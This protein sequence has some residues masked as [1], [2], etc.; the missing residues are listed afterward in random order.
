MADVLFDIE[1]TGI[2]D[3]RDAAAN[4]QR[5]GKVS[6][7][8]ASQY[9]PL[10]SQTTRLVKEQ[11]RLE[12]SYKALAKAEKQNLI[13][14][15]E[16][17]RAMEEEI[18]VSKERILTDS[19]LIAQQRKKAKSEERSK[20]ETE[21]LTKAYAPARMAADLFQKKLKEIDR[22]AKGGIISLKEAAIATARTKTEFAQ[23]SAGLATGANQ[24][25]RFNTAAYNA[26]QKSKRFASV[27][28]QQV[29]YQV[30]DFIV[31]MQSGTD[32]LVAFGQQGSQL[33][34]IFGAKGAIFGAVIA[35]ATAIGMVYK[36]IVE[37]SKTSAEDIKTAF[38]TVPDYFDDLGLSIFNS[39]DKSFSK[40][41]DRYG[42][43]IGNLARTQLTSLQDAAKS[44]EGPTVKSAQPSIYERIGSALAPGLVSG[45]QDATSK[46]KAEQEKAFAE[47]VEVNKI[48]E[49]YKE[50]VGEIKTQSELFKLI[51]DTHGEILLVSEKAAKA[52][53]KQAKELGIAKAIT[54]EVKALTEKRLK[55]Q[56]KLNKIATDATVLEAELMKEIA[57]EERKRGDLYLAKRQHVIDLITKAEQEA[58]AKINKLESLGAT[59]LSKSR[60]AA[61]DSI[62]EA[63][64][65]AVLK[66]AELQIDRQ[67]VVAIGYSQLRLEA[68][69]TIDAAEKVF[70]EKLQKLDD[71]RTKVY[72]KDRREAIAS[73]YE[74]ERAE[75]LR[76]A[77][78]QRFITT[79]RNQARVQMLRTISDAE[80]AFA[81]E[82]AEKAE[83]EAAAQQKIFQKVEDYITSLSNEYKKTVQLRDVSEDQLELQ[84]ALIDAKQKYGS[85]ATKVQMDVIEV[86][87]K[88]IDVEKQYQQV[89]EEAQKT[90][91][92]VS[93]SLGSSL[94]AAMMSIVDGTASVKDAFKEMAAAV[95]KDLYRILV[96]EQ[97]VASF[98]VATGPFAAAMGTLGVA[99]GAAFSGGSP[100]KAY[101]NGGVVGGPTYFPMRGNRVGLMGEAGPEAIMPL[102]R[103][104]DGKLG[105]QASGQA[106]TVNQNIN[107]STGV[108]QTVRT[109]IKSLMPQIAEASKAAV[110]DA[111]R[112][113][114]SYGRTFS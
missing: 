48:L 79:A 71:F 7:K 56:K 46:V 108:Q 32:V 2:K 58:A 97:L 34:G 38:S 70:A 49:T 33:A 61:I 20:R 21:R 50:Q 35:G 3:L 41:E 109:E 53:E 94:E 84:S 86:T 14:K 57:A 98:K 9:K 106:V 76:T 90:Q 88:L 103:G 23:F 83:K 91:E 101:A 74:A 4:F 102:S 104:K 111:K 15:P 67:R 107:I 68:L 93:E 28:L 112:R 110:S 80:K 113:G 81:D 36:G 60:R 47:S 40:I 37:A 75:I 72:S 26:T 6:T 99:N 13:D 65:E 77:D 12:A 54:D 73:I 92:R 17:I 55:D 42:M 10:G 31:Q 114:G 16:L 69:A 64:R 18:R 8:L 30:G 63:E 78:L 62:Y 5:L 43:L 39:F 96:V 85:T 25:A 66:S 19:K 95:I 105:V 59:A 22:A 45:N 51:K 44:I 100:I 82:Q 52:F 29:G 27:G 11:K 24:F 1:V 87:L 89:L